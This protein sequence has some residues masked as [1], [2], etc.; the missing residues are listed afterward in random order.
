MFPLLLHCYL[1]EEIFWLIRGNYKDLKEDD[2]VISS[3]SSRR[4]WNDDDDGNDD[5]DVEVSTVA[6]EVSELPWEITSSISGWVL[7]GYQ[8]FLCLHFNLNTFTHNSDTQ[9]LFEVP[10]NIESCKWI[11]GAET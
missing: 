1:L 11:Q 6:G 7:L 10:S 9:H 3:S 2:P 5:D 8:T 4:G